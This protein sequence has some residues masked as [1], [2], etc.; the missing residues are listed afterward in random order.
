MFGSREQK[1]VVIVTGASGGI[2]KAISL[3]LA[4]LNFNVIVN[5]RG[6][7]VDRVDGKALNPLSISGSSQQYN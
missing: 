4:K 7:N 5:Y 6:H 1:K 2:G 3:E